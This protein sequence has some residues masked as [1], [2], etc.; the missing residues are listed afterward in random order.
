MNANEKITANIESHADWRGLVLSEIRGIVLN[1]NTAIQEEWKW[2][3]P[4]WSLNGMLY[5]ASAFKKH[6]SITFFQGAFLDDPDKL[7]NGNESKNN[8]SIILKEG[9]KIDESALKALISNA[10]DYNMK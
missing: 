10:I 7:F 6:V 3:S 8:R 5:S 4:V 1:S 9:D 2:N